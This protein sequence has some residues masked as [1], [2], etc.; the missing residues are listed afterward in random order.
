MLEQHHTEALLLLH[1]TKYVYI[2]V[3]WC[4][5][6]TDNRRM[7]QNQR[8]RRLLLPRKPDNL[9]SIEIL[10]PFLRTK[11]GIKEVFVVSDRYTKR[12]ETIQTGTPLTVTIAIIFM[13]RYV[14]SFGIRSTVLTNAEP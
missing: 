4:F 14:E 13:A 12:T 6:W 2:K 8:K 5:L 7:N 3:S 11:D 10:G 1:V 9:V